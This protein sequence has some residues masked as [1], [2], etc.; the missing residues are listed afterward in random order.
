MASVESLHKASMRW[1]KATSSKYLVKNN[2]KYVN[3][4]YIQ[5]CIQSGPLYSLL[6]AHTANPVLRDHLFWRTT[7]FQQKDLNINITEPVTET[8]HMTWQTTFLWPMGWS[9]KIGSTVALNYGKIYIVLQ[10][11]PALQ[12]TGV[13][14]ILGDGHISGPVLFLGWS[15]F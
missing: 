8:D 10:W 12:P 9:F 1:C 6:I 14:F 7:H 4:T 2:R 13:V 11:D 5:N 3:N 15:Y